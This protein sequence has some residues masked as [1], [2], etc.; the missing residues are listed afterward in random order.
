[1]PAFTS[2]S[3]TA[4]TST[5]FSLRIGAS[6]N[7]AKLIVTLGRPIAISP[8]IFTV[9]VLAALQYPLSCARRRREQ[10]SATPAAAATIRFFIPIPYANS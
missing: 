1:M 5:G 4:L 2:A 7:V 3:N 8:V 9:S 6:G 10:A